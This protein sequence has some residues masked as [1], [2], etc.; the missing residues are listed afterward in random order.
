MTIGAFAPFPQL[1]GFLRTMRPAFTSYQALSGDNLITEAILLSG[2]KL[3]A[4]L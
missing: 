1:P 3:S 4:K 2:Q